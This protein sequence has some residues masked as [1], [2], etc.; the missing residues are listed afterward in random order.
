MPCTT[1]IQGSSIA[2]PGAPSGRTIEHEWSGVF[3]GSP[4]YLPGSDLPGSDQHVATPDDSYVTEELYSVKT[5][6]REQILGAPKDQRDVYINLLRRRADIKRL[7]V[8]NAAGME[9]AAAAE[10]K[11]SRV[12]QRLASY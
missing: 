7:K 10:N 4:R 5:A 1:P 3:A 12:R 9:K 8:S 11:L 6:L 2:V